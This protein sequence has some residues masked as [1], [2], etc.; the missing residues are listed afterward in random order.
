MTS[1]ATLKSFNLALEQRV[2]SAC[3]LL[4]QLSLFQYALPLPFVWV[5]LARDL[6]A[7]EYAFPMAPILALR[8]GVLF[9]WLVFSVSIQSSKDF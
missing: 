9:Y 5:T 3:R 8:Q 6:R 1:A 2:F 7:L 4:L